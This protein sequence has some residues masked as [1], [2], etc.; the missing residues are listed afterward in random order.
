[1]KMRLIAQNRMTRLTARN[2]A[3]RQNAARTLLILMACC[4]L[5]SCLLFVNASTSDHASIYN[6]IIPPP[7]PRRKEPRRLDADEASSFGPSQVRDAAAIDG[8]SNKVMESSFERQQGLH[9]RPPP[10]P[11]RLDVSR[12]ENEELHASAATTPSIEQQT[13]AVQRQYVMSSEDEQQQ[14]QQQAIKPLHRVQPPP[15]PPRPR[16]SNDPLDAATTSLPLTQVEGC[17]D[18][19]GAASQNA[20]SNG[21]ADEP[22]D[23]QSFSPPPLPR[24][25]QQQ[26]QQLDEPNGGNGSDNL[27][28]IVSAVVAAASS[29]SILRQSTNPS[30]PTE[31]QSTKNVLLDNPR[32]QS[33]PPLPPYKPQAL[34]AL[35]EGQPDGERAETASKRHDA[36]TRLKWSITANEQSVTAEYVN[37]ALAQVLPPAPQQEN[38]ESNGDK[39]DKFEAT[40]QSTDAS[41]TKQSTLDSVL[42]HQQAQSTHP[43]EN[44]VET[45]PFE[46]LKAGT[47]HSLFDGAAPPYQRRAASQAQPLPPGNHSPQVVHESFS[48]QLGSE[49]LLDATRQSSAYDQ[50]PGEPMVEF[51]QIIV[52]PSRPATLLNAQSDD[53]QWLDG[54]KRA[55]EQGLSSEL[56]H[57][58]Q[59]TATRSRND[60]FGDEQPWPTQQQPTQSLNTLANDERGMQPRQ[61]VP[62]SRPAGPLVQRQ[63]QRRPLQQS[64]FKPSS[65]SQPVWERLW[66]KV[67]TG[68]DT[69][70]DLEDGL[71]SRAQKLYSTTVS[72]VRKGGKERNSVTRQVQESLVFE[73]AAIQGNRYQQA[74]ILSRSTAEIDMSKL[75]TA[76]HSGAV[77]GQT[78]RLMLANGGSSA[79]PDAAF[80]QQQNP[81]VQGP[82]PHAQTQHQQYP[83]PVMERR[84][85]LPVQNRVAPLPQSVRTSPFVAARN[86]AQQQEQRQSSATFQSP[87]LPRE[88][89]NAPSSPG[90]EDNIVKVDQTSSSN[91]F[92]FDDDDT[93]RFNF[94]RLTKMM[95]SI[96]RLRFPRL[97][98]RGGSFRRDDALAALDLWNAA[99]D[100]QPKGFMS[101][102]FGW[103]SGS[104]PK[105]NSLSIVVKPQKSDKDEA[106]VAMPQL[107]K[108]LMQRCGNGKSTTLLSKDDKR[109]GGTIGRMLAALDLLVLCGIM[110]AVRETRPGNFALPFSW[111][112]LVFEAV[113]ALFN[114]IVASMNG[115]LP[116][117]LAVIYLATKTSELIQAGYVNLLCD[118][119][120]T[121]IVNE[122]RTGSLFLR[123]YMGT[124]VDQQMTTNM[125][126]AATLQVREK[127]LVSRLRSFVFSL[128]ATLVAMTVAIRQSLAKV[129]FYSFTSILSIEELHLWPVLAHTFFVNAR[130]TLYKYT[131]TSFSMLMQS[132]KRMMDDPV[133]VAYKFAVFGV[134]IAAAYVPRIEKR[135]NLSPA[136]SSDNEEVE[137]AH[138]HSRLTESLEDLGSSSGTRLCALSEMSAIEAGLE[139]WRLM[140]PQDNESAHGL[141][142]ASFIRIIFYNILAGLLLFAPV[143]AFAFGGIAPLGS[144]DATRIRWDSLLDVSIILLYTHQL[145]TKALSSAVVAKEAEA[146]IAT[147]IAKIRNAVQSRNHEKESQRNLELQAA[148]NPLA[149]LT[150]KDLWAA[151]ATRRA[152]AVRGISL[153]VQNSEIVVLF[154]EG[155]SGKTRL[156]T[157]LAEAMVDPPREALS[158]TRVRGTTI[159]CGVETSKW[160]KRLLRRRLGLLL[161]DVQTLSAVSKAFSGMSIEEILEPTSLKR[162]PEAARN[163]MILGLKVTGLYA[164][165]IPRLPS[166]LSTII[167]AVEED[168]RPS[169][170]RPRSGDSIDKCLI[171]SIL[172][173]DDA[174]AH[175]SEVDEAR[176]LQELRRTGAAIVIASN[177]WATGRFV[178]RIVVL[179]DGAAMESGTHNQLLARGPQYSLYA[180]QWNAMATS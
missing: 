132:V 26:Q 29:S 95:P 116:F 147:F 55:Q 179:K 59:S 113:P 62:L 19:G 74:S 121:S 37:A 131:T 13:A 41:D 91:K 58:T 81:P 112:E 50:G 36:D 17:T 40:R 98:N 119:V 88:Q 136:S 78:R 34:E 163:A 97:F 158:A 90:N 176:L 5:D 53:K 52:H 7:P 107:L 162:S 12:V 128:L 69:L 130:D 99:D 43:F 39:K 71:Q 9:Q 151:H 56:P 154:G 64:T 106:N 68:L 110:V 104:R 103:A 65:T 175:F 109:R 153:D 114:M 70:A 44:Q 142:S 83:P 167:T 20:V 126:H 124:P 54:S 11:S 82:P 27:Q 178:D 51:E 135:R 159:V 160:D 115:W 46:C 177:R 152:W 45:V 92:S 32:L 137:A 21:K 72:T 165:L 166:K 30:S 79:P 100:D 67:E 127:V 38:D 125:Q 172:L 174:T 4:C 93:S 42:D 118:D 117:A 18:D 164:S 148:I 139:R 28:P 75:S 133:I 173:L 96:P 122:A 77:T 14:Q 156:L 47:E 145:L 155:G 138:M 73:I 31:Q 66:K 76:D 10:P 87:R 22:V 161:N 146:Y 15:P 143:I 169:S 85:Q 149:G 16:S 63:L 2:G 111:S 80:S 57:S 61:T 168:L 89:Q 123:L 134:L 180:A 1:M 35:P 48:D 33:T 23:L 108:D 101:K 171:G 129:A 150:V 102:M 86:N 141:S 120:S 60:N 49:R 157:T 140:L 6:G 25:T 84:H 24:L 3:V 94:S 105:I 170:L 8:S 144:T